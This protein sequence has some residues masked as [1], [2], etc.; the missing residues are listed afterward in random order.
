MIKKNKKLTFL[1][2]NIKNI[3]CCQL[4]LHLATG[5]LDI[6]NEKPSKIKLFKEK[7]KEKIIKPV[8]NVQ[9][10]PPVSNNKK[11]EDYF[12]KIK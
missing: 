6:Q 3:I 1:R 12:K 7:E 11:I 4:T 5:I 10:M 2:C 8:E 9:K